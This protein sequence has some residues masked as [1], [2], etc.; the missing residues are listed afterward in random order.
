MW[1]HDQGLI[2]ANAYYWKE[3]QFLCQ[4][5][6]AHLESKTD[7]IELSIKLHQTQFLRL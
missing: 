3:L 1:L 7:I 2:N 6:I 5:S 4:L